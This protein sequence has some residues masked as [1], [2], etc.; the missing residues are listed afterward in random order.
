MEIS[1]IF[2]EKTSVWEHFK[3]CGKPVALYGM[4]DGAD[5]VLDAFERFGIEVSGVFASDGFVRGQSF[6]GFTVRRLEELESELGELAVALCFASQL[7]DVMAQIKR[8]AQ[9]P[10]CPPCRRSAT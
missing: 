10:A 5:K 1:G 6:R 9:T 2:A 8:V 3:S 7:P 4:G